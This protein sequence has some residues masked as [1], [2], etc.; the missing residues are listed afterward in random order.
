[1]ET[2]KWSRHMVKGKPWDRKIEVSENDFG[3]IMVVNLV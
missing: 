2:S 3:D 1:M